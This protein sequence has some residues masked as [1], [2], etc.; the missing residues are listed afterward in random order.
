[1]NYLVSQ[2]LSFRFSLN[3][4]KGMP[5]RLRRR[6]SGFL[7]VVKEYF[8]SLKTLLISCIYAPRNILDVS[9]N[10]RT[11]I[12]R[13]T[14]DDHVYHVA[15][16]KPG[17]VFTN[18]INNV[19]ILSGKS[20][21][22]L[23]SWQWDDNGLVVLQD[24][25]NFL[26]TRQ[27]R[28]TQPPKFYKATIVSLLS[29]APANFNYYHWLFDSLPRLWVC[30][31]IL[32]GHLSVKYL[33]PDDALPFQ[34][35]TLKELGINRSDCISSRDVPFLAASTLIATSYPNP[36][37]DDPA[38]WTIDFL[39]KAFLHLREPQRAQSHFLYISRR[40]SLRSRRLINE[41]YLLSLLIPLGFTV[42]CLSEIGF[43]EQVRL[44]ANAKIVVGVHG[45][46]LANLLFA[47]SGTVV[48]ELVAKCY[49]PLMFQKIS[50][51][52]KLDHNTIIC[53]SSETTDFCA[54]S[55]GCNKPTLS[56]AKNI[57]NLEISTRDALAISEQAR[58][59]IDN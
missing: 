25:H 16:I 56:F 59:M 7:Y 26:L 11:R 48:Y 50:R 13:R 54:D 31:S 40:D 2:L 38:T 12:L 1:M 45:A 39:R 19:S 20:L 41:E 28:L 17:V 15:V 55:D 14:L 36:K 37:V 43:S 30:D 34:I 57:A 24:K 29:G 33:I 4:S 42:V 49:Q 32:D 9:G 35:E 44:F 47:E 27:I 46:G 3:C 6:F 22:P 52:L 18:R 8:Y 51:Y 5:A 23:V 58:A 53:A 10:P 21:V